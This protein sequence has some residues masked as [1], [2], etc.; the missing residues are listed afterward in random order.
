MARII[1]KRDLE[2]LNDFRPPFVRDWCIEH[3]P[4][5]EF[6]QTINRCLTF[7]QLWIL[8]GYGVPFYIITGVI[9]SVV[10]EYIFNGLCEVMD[11]TYTQIRNRWY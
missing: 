8:M 2:R 7:E 11:V 6:C 1:S 5:D 3:Y 10:R 9:D 4:D